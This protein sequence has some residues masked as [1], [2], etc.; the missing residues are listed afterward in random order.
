M[1]M[2]SFVWR[3]RMP[4]STASTVSK[5]P[6]TLHGGCTAQCRM[7]GSLLSS[8]HQ[9]LAVSSGRTPHM[10]PQVGCFLQ[11]SWMP[12][13]Y[14][15]R[16]MSS[17]SS[18]PRER[19]SLMM[20]PRQLDAA[21]SALTGGALRGVLQLPGAVVLQVPALHWR[22]LCNR[23]E[24]QIVPVNEHAQLRWRSA[25]AAANDTDSLRSRQQL[26]VFCRGRRLPQRLA[27]CIASK[28]W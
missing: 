12:D 21:V 26:A 4:G 7:L 28:A 24:V 6:A 2:A 3:D 15:A 14:Q 10:V 5:V 1:G 13:V 18:S 11:A 16:S 17:H 23:R 22:K 27:A 25:A 20:G 9:E 19:H 8:R